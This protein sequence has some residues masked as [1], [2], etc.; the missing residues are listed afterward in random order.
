MRQVKLFVSELQ[1]AKASWE[2]PDFMSGVG[3]CAKNLL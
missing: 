2:K 3:D 1:T